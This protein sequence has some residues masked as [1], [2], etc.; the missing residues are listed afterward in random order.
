MSEK[1]KYWDLIIRSERSLVFL[2]AKEIIR[3]GDLLKLLVKRD[4]LAF[5]KQT[6]LGP[7]WFVIQPLFTMGV[8]VFVF[9]TLA[10]LPTD[11]LPQPLFYLTGIT[12]WTYFSQTLLKTSTILKDNANI[13]GKVY[14]PRVIMPLSLVISNLFKLGIHVLL[15]LIIAFYFSFQDFDWSVSYYLLVLPVLVVLLALQAFGFGMIVSSLTTRYRDLALLLAFG[16][17]LLMYA[18]PVVFPLSTLDGKMKLIVSINPTSFLF[19]GFRKSLFNQGLF[20]WEYLLT[21][22]LITFV[23]LISGIIVFNRVERNFVDTI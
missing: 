11:G 17:Q 18:T 14:F 3:Y 16:I 1:N 9:G 20:D 21:T 13:L 12:F 6:V 23:I 15:L 5:Y 10:G 19:E 22:T 7:L 8:Y 4:I 2:D